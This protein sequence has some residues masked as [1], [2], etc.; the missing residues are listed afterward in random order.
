MRIVQDPKILDA[1]KGHKIPFYSK[2]FQSKIPSQPIVRRE[3]EELV[4]LEVKE[5]LKKGA[6]TKIQ[7]SKG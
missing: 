3:E 4:K 5:L 6:I 1:E 2:L 7:P